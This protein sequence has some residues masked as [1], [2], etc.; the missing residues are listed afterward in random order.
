MNEYHVN[1]IKIKLRRFMRLHHRRESER[2]HTRNAGP[3]RSR[4][5]VPSPGVPSR[6]G[7]ARPPG[8]TWP[9]TRTAAQSR[10]LLRAGPAAGPGRASLQE[11]GGD[12]GHP[13][14]L[15]CVGDSGA[16]WGP[17]CVWNRRR[18]RALGPGPDGEGH[19]RVPPTSR[20]AWKE[21]RQSGTAPSF[22]DTWAIPGRPPARGDGAC[23]A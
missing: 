23:G 17:S 6:P 7:S 4:L 9:H 16:P 15:I 22:G 14:R 5:R 12:G 10:C 8:T 1:C 21:Q 2:P 11:Q 3:A 19:P 20:A 18:T 13:G